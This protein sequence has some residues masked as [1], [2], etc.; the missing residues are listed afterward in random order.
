[1]CHSHTTH[2]G[3]KTKEPA[4][5]RARKAAAGAGRHVKPCHLKEM[6][7]DG[8]LLVMHFL[9]SVS[10]VLL[11]RT[12]RIYFFAIA[13]RAAAW[14]YADAITI[15]P[16]YWTVSRP[17]S[18]ILQHAPTR[19]DLGNSTS[20]TVYTAKLTETVGAGRQLRE[21][22]SCNGAVARGSYRELVS[23]PTL[24]SGLE[25]L[26]LMDHHEFQTASLGLAALHLQHLRS[27]Q[28][29]GWTE[30]SA[31]SFLNRFPS[32]TDLELED[33]LSGM[34][35]H[36]ISV[37][38]QVHLAGVTIPLTRLCLDSPNRNGTLL[39]Q[40]LVLPAFIT[41]KCLEFRFLDAMTVTTSLSTT[42]LEATFRAMHSLHKLVLHYVNG[43]SII[44]PHVHHA[45]NLRLVE[46]RAYAGFDQDFTR[47]RLAH[48]AHLA[49]ALQA[50]KLL[51]ITMTSP[52]ADGPS[53]DKARIYGQGMMRLTNLG[54]RF[55]FAAI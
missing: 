27:I 8:L 21:L 29:V 9:D 16:A 14:R 25:R 41:V 4:K 44:L 53:F 1:M 26:I 36:N 33:R 54:P 42:E 12:N 45:V 48:P 15:P 32:L 23:H 10:R 30:V 2:R 31:L 24:V 34:S 39:L 20:V 49:Q 17:M 7:L 5:K 19:I 50:N 38:T 35:D 52:Q 55:S 11:G 40:G 6:W 47:S 3:K 46:I 28:L 22:T 37:L 51:H 18:A 43:A 13:S